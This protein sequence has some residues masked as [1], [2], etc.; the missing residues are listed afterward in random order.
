L[1]AKVNEKPG[2]L[3][4]SEFTTKSFDPAKGLGFLVRRAVGGGLTEPLLFNLEPQGAGWRLHIQDSDSAP[5][6]HAIDWK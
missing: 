1:L 4:A 5:Q 2:L 3:V 6:L